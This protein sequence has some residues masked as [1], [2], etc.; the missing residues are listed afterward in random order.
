MFIMRNLDWKFIASNFKGYF[1]WNYFD[2]DQ[3]NWKNRMF[4]KIEIRKSGNFLTI[5]N[6]ENFRDR[7]MSLKNPVV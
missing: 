2:R 1:N 5:N 7:Q 4:R 6:S 3:K